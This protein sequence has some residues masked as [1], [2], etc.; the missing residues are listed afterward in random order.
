MRF[1]ACKFAL[2]STLAAHSQPLREPGN[3]HKSAG[4]HSD[5]LLRHVLGAALT[6]SCG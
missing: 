1:F 6:V 4:H 2:K 5:L 3:P